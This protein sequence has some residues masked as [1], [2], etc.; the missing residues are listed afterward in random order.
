MRVDHLS[1]YDIGDEPVRLLKKI[2][3]TI[4]NIGLKTEEK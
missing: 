2:H 1:R 3:A 4:F